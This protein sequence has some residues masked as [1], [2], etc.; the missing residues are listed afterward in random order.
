M[1]LIIFILF[2]GHYFE[3]L[4]F[5]TFGVVSLLAGILILKLPETLNKQ[6]PDNLDQAERIHH[7]SDSNETT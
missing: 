7:Y 2:K 4:P 5:L 1:L 3:L 6:L